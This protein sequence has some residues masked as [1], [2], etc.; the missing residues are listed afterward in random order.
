MIDSIMVRTPAGSMPMGGWIGVR[1]RFWRDPPRIVCNV[2]RRSRSRARIE[3][4]LGINQEGARG[5]DLFAEGK[6]IQHSET[7]ARAGT[8]NHFTPLIDSGLG[9]DVN[10][11]ARPGIDDR[12]LGYAQNLIARRRCQIGRDSGRAQPL[13][14]AGRRREQVQIFRPSTCTETGS[15]IEPSLAAVTGQFFWSWQC[16]GSLRASTAGAGGL[17]HSR[18]IAQTRACRPSVL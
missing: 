12:R 13:A 6:P 1:V 16:A 3:P 7:V 8:E 5:R 14:W 18:P 15:P 10:D 9:F 11:L 17:G 2:V 4:A